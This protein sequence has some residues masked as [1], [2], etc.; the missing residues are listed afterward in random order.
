MSW[1]KQRSDFQ[2]VEFERAVKK[3]G[4][5]V[6]WEKSSI[7]PCIPKNASGQPNPI[8]PLCLGKG[9]YWYDPIDIQGVMVNFSEEER[10]NQTGEVVAG[11]SYFTTLPQYKLGFWDRITHWHSFIRY[12]ELIEK[13]AHG[14]KDKLRFIPLDILKLRTVEREYTFEAD[15]KIDGTTRYI[16]WSPYLYEP[17]S[18]EQYS[19]EYTMNPCWIVIDITNVLRDTYTKSKK[20]GITFTEL[21]VRAV[22]RLEYFVFDK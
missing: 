11:T 14:G 10:L 17:N 20:P 15:F 8:C 19:V 6:S 13:G 4:Y 12:S 1:I 2:T 21:P 16:D 22:V 9:R 7:C 3:Y 18:G 5:V